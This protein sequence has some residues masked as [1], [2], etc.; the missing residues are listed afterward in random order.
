M[1]GTINGLL[2][3][4]IALIPGV[5][6]ETIFSEQTGLDWREDQLRRVIRTVVISIAGLIA[7]VLLDDFLQYA[8]CDLPNPKYINPYYL[9][10]GFSRSVL[11]EMAWSYTGHVILSTL[12]GWGAAVATVKRSEN[13]DSPLYP[14]AWDDLIRTHVPGRWVLV[15]LTN[16]DRY[17]GV[18]ETA[19]TGVPSND[20]DI[21][22]ADPVLFDEDAGGYVETG[23]QYLFLPAALISSV[24]VL[25]NPEVTKRRRSASES[26]SLSNR[27]TETS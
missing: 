9:S 20:R 11:S 3:L 5:P 15:G 12:I 24:S 8:R 27:K 6:G 13:S 22:L 10:S 7:Y 19:D 23:N 1:V 21:S 4:A 25:R 16:G 17:K 2:I 14:A 18:I 26:L